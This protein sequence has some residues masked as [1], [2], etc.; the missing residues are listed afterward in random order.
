MSGLAFAVP[1]SSVTYR[2][3]IFPAF[4]AT[5][6]GA[7]VDLVRRST[8]VEYIEQDGVMSINYE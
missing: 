6:K 7:D 5:M 3:D 4:A 1:G 8:G 2:Y